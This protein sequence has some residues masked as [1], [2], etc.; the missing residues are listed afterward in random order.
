MGRERERGQ[1]CFEGTGITRARNV[2]HATRD[3]GAAWSV[4]VGAT[5]GGG[6]G[7]DSLD[8]AGHGHVA[9]R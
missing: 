2:T 8:G 7:G 1:R 5:T 3:R 4:A 6:R 9:M